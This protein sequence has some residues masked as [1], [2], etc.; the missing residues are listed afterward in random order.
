MG[1]LGEG[2][3]KP[4]GRSVTKIKDVLVKSDLKPMSMYE[5]IDE[6]SEKVMSRS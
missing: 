6:R 4:R 1:A 2:T 3:G 5:K